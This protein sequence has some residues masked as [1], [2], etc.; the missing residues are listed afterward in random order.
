MEHRAQVVAD[1]LDDRGQGVPVGDV[2]GGDRHA[3]AG[4]FGGAGGVRA[5]AGHQDDVVGAV[6]NEPAGDDA[7]QAHPCPR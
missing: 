7:A 2:A 6:F 5:L 3:V 1:R 4:Q